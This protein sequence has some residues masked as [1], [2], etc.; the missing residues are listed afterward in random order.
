M[1]F[2]QKKYSKHMDKL[3]K[4]I[5]KKCNQTLEKKNKG[6]LNILLKNTLEFYKQKA[7]RTNKMDLELQ[8]FK[9]Y[10]LKIYSL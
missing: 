4:F 2:I 10:K 5:Q 1:K 9:Y 8:K 6:Q 3:N 7:L